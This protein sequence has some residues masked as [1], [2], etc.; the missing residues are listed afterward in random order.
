MLYP[1]TKAD[2]PIG[3][4]INFLRAIEMLGAAMTE[5]A[6]G[7]VTLRPIG[8]L[9]LPHEKSMNLEGQGHLGDVPRSSQGT[10]SSLFD[11]V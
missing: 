10:A 6:P 4:R 11:S 9:G 2:V 3:T 1:Q 5:R 7:A 8:V